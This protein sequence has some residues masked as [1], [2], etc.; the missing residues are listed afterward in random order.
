MKLKDWKINGRFSALSAFHEIQIFSGKECHCGFARPGRKPAGHR[1]GGRRAGSSSVHS[2][3]NGPHGPRAGLGSRPAASRAA[4]KRPAHQRSEA[5]SAPPGSSSTVTTLVK[6]GAQRCRQPARGC[7]A[8]SGGARP[9]GS[10][11]CQSRWRPSV[12]LSSR[13]NVSVSPAALRHTHCLLKGRPM[14]LAKGRH[15]TARKR[16]GR[17]FEPQIHSIG[18]Q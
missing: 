15:V 6:P 4:W 18:A 5:P 7:R 1:S 11:C 3:Y 14:G 9:S 16:P 13:C 2:G 10:S 12:A 8:G 17:V